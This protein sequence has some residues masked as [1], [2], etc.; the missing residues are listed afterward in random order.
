MLITTIIIAVITVGVAVLGL[1]LNILLRKN[2]RF[3]V[4]SVGHN[5]EMR[6]RGITCA[7]QDE[8]ISFN[9]SRRI[10]QTKSNELPGDATDCGHGCS[11]APNSP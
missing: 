4:T 8:I 5:S 10:A 7:K 6:K 9:R 3:P 1:G 11:C 2:G